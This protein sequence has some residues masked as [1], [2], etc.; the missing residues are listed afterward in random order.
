[1]RNSITIIQ[2]LWKRSLQRTMLER[3]RT[4]E[5]H[6]RNQRW[7]IPHHGVYHSRKPDKIRVVFDCSAKHGGTL[8]NDQLISGPDLTNSLISVLTRFR[9]E[10]VAFMADIEPMFYQVRVPEDQRDL[11]RFMWWPN[12]DI[13]QDLQEYQ[14]NVHLFRAV[15][16]PSC[17][18]FCLK[19]AAEDCINEVGI[20]TADV[21]KKNFYVDDCLRSDK[22]EDLATERIEGVRHVC[23][24]G[25]FHLTKFT[26]N[27]RNVLNSIPEKERSKNTRTVDLNHSQLP[28][29]RALWALNG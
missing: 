19:K 10:P 1:M 17:A 11:L 2:P 29:E 26:S 23:Y 16:S 8:L 15:S 9:Q 21:L 5:N 14:M 6:Q 18:N 20:D 12:G 25:G 22:T 13:T 4:M 28:I 7:Y 27:Q 24:R 3:C